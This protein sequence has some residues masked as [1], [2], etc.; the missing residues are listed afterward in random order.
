MVYLVVY[1]IILLY[2]EYSVAPDQLALPELNPA[3]LDTH[4]FFHTHTFDHYITFFF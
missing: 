1:V 3:V 2:S 4:S